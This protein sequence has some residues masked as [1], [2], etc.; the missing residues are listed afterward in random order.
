MTSKKDGEKNYVGYIALHLLIKATVYGV[1]VCQKL[2]N[3]LISK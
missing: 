3:C 1:K 2:T